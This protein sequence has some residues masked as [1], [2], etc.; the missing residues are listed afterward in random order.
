MA[1][2]WKRSASFRGDE[3]ARIIRNNINNADHA[4]KLAEATDRVNRVHALAV[5]GR[6]R[7]QA[8]NRDVQWEEKDLGKFKAADTLLTEAVALAEKSPRQWRCSYELGRQF[9]DLSDDYGTGEKR[10]KYREKAVA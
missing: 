4:G 1:E 5:R 7:L 10:R 9:L 3:A 2:N 8:L 6:A